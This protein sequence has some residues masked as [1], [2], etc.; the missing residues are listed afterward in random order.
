MVGHRVLGW[1]TGDVVTA[2]L[3]FKAGMTATLSAVLCTPHFIRCHVF[4]SEK[5]IEVRNESHPD[6]PGGRVSYTEAISGQD[7]ATE[8][9]DWT[10]AVV[11]NLEAFRAACKGTAPYPF[12]PFEMMH[13][14]EVLEAIARSAEDRR[15]VRID[16]LR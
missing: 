6:T 3:G 8:W 13:N 12:T 2:Q 5:W 4:G 9:L 14:I 7:P 11:E 1:E 10:D 15:A 16:E